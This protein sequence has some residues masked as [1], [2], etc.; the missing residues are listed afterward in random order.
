MVAAAVRSSSHKVCSGQEAC[1]DA[2]NSWP[3]ERT[4]VLSEVTLSLLLSAMNRP[5]RKAGAPS[6]ASFLN[7]GRG[8]PACIEGNFG[9]D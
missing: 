5:C 6:L 1:T 3:I 7:L 4:R 9:V 2:L 8:S